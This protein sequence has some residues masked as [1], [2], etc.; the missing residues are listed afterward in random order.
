VG[1]SRNYLFLILFIFAFLIF[2]PIRSSA[3]CPPFFAFVDK[4][5]SAYPECL[6]ISEGMFCGGDLEVK[7]NC[8]DK[9]LLGGKRIFPG[10][11]EYGFSEVGWDYN[12]TEQQSQR[13][14]LAGDLNGKSFVLK[15]QTENWS[16]KNS[17]S[18]LIRTI[19][20]IIKI[21][22]LLVVLL[23]IPIAIF[24]LRKSRR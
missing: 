17:F 6:E 9:V 13:W 15:G 12:S 18:R 3:Y 21:G 23:L 11:T 4:D 1:R 7:N 20:S 10:K 14:E 22:F 16:D 19:P 5:Q 8:S 2:L 24:T